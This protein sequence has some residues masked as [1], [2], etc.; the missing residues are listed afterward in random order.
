MASF[1]DPV[2][3]YLPDCVST[4]PP[5]YRASCEPQKD[6]IFV[7]LG[8]AQAVSPSWNVF[9]SP[10]LANGIHPFGPRSSSDKSPFLTFQDWA[11]GI[12]WDFL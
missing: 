3:A 12:L 2:S 4:F 6:A 1:Y 10:F 11:D 8:F 9:I 7:S 5:V